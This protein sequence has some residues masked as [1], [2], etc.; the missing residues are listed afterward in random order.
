M[1]QHINDADMNFQTAKCILIFNHF[2]ALRSDTCWK[3]VCKCSSFDV[4]ML[5]IKEHTNTMEQTDSGSIRAM[6]I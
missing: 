2:E 3:C 6:L 4:M 1:F 5:G